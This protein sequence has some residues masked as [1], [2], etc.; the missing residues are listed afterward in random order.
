MLHRVVRRRV[1]A[2]AAQ[3]PLVACRA[4]APLELALLRRRGRD[5]WDAARLQHLRGRKQLQP[6]AP[7]R[8]HDQPL[9][10]AR[11]LQQAPPKAVADGAEPAPVRPCVPVLVGEL[12]AVRDAV[13]VRP[14]APAQVRRAG[15]APWVQRRD[16]AP[17]LERSVFAGREDANL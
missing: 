16:I 15:P 3:G 10:A 13:V 12:A 17:G 2:R 1:G 7:P 8:T 6:P 14:W 9:R 5:E 4:R 11:P